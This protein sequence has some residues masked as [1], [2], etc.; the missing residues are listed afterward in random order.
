MIKIS[1]VIIIGGGPGGLTAGLYLARARMQPLL[2]EKLQ[3]GGQAALIE[4]IEN[5]PGFPKEVRGPDIVRNI[6]EQATELGL[7]IV[8][9]HEVRE[10]KKDR[11]QRVLI[12]TLDEEYEC[13]AA[14]VASGASCKKLG[15]P[16]EE[17]L[18]GRGVSYCASC[19]G[20]LF[21]N[22]DV[23]VVGGGD[24]ALHEA[25]FLSELCRKVTIIHSGDELEGTKLLQ[26][27]TSSR[28][29][30]SFIWQSVVRKIWGS[31]TVNGVEIEDRLSG[32]VRDVACKG[33]FVFTGMSPNTGFLENFLELD[34]K[35]FIVSDENMRTS[36]EGI[37]VCGD[38]RRKLLR[39]V[40]TACGDGATAA[41]AAER[42][43]KE[44]QHDD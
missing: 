24:M 34:G 21:K 5:F 33:V 3:I 35:G 31:Y 1:K 37:F 44:L 10:I 12:G 40:V 42:Y 25:L 28:R 36:E 38:V 26:E 14:I 29:N 4:T 39:Q 43:I 7:E 18:S 13:L 15:V 22:E 17:A 32:K 20:P 9:N 41:A 30:I 8:S 16:G 23:I 11:G 27:R 6:A 2:I 19:D